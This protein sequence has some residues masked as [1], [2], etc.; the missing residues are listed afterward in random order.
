MIIPAILKKIHT[1]ND[2][3]TYGTY[4]YIYIV[5]VFIY[6]MLFLFLQ[7][8]RKFLSVFSDTLKS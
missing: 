7:A 4:V 1:Y 2:V 3:Y 8:N 6:Y 5:I